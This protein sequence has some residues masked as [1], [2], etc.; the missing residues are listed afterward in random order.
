M[1]KTFLRFLP[2]WIFLVF[3]KFGGALHYS[4]VSPLGER[5]LPLW[6]VGLIM[7]G[8]SIVQFLLD[9]PA[10]HLLDRY[11]Y[12]KLLKLTTFIFLFAAVAYIFDFTLV[13]YLISMVVSTFGWLFFGPGVNAYILSHAPREY[14][15]RF[16]SLRDVSGSIG[17]VLS[18][19]VLPFVVLFTPR[20]MGWVIFALLFI[21]WISL[22]FSPE[23]THSVHEEIKLPTQHH[24][25]KRNSLAV[26]MKAMKK[27]DPASSMLLIAGLVAGIFYGAIWFVVPLVIASQAAGSEL[28]GIGLG[29][30]DF[31]IVL[32]G[33]FLGNLADRAN[34]RSLVFFGLLV[35]SI[36]GM[37][38]GFNFGWLFLL[39]GFLATS[40]DEMSEISLWSWLHSLDRE[41]D[42]DGLISGVINFFSDVGWAIGP[43]MAGFLYTVI[44]PSWTILIAALPILVAWMVYQFIL[45]R[46]RRYGISPVPV[47][48]KPHRARH[49]T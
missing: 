42:S 14:A 4:L 9:V 18:S 8:G 1:T 38:I 44:G 46:H 21:A 28:L 31:A 36:S 11:G 19:A 16:M 41:H 34:R 2:F 7:G 48:R 25:I 39:F 20:A 35:F 33:F 30:F 3:F 47:P 5:V 43:I 27:L 37:L 22:Y 17:V 49:R 24:Y 23:D 13:T 40:G 10:G 6:I 15:G 26:T 45:K 12:R 32:L 29:I